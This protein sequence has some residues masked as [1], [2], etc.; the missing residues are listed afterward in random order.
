MQI[1][2]HV[3]NTDVAKGTWLATEN[4]FLTLFRMQL[5]L[6]GDAI[7]ARCLPVDRYW[8]E[9]FLSQMLRRWG[10]DFCC[11]SSGLNLVFRCRQDSACKMLI[12]DVIWAAWA[13]SLLD[14]GLATAFIELCAVAGA[15]LA[16]IA[17]IVTL[18]SSRWD[19]LIWLPN[20]C[21]S[22]H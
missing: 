4:V 13:T 6:E 16:L 12:Q 2:T 21:S 3:C 18:I 5:I 10:M 14:A 1:R 17:A 7:D 8:T 22:L 11:T 19:N 15:T 20:C 9:T